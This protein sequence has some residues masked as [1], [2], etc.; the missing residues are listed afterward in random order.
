MY[1]TQLASDT[2]QKCRKKL[3][4]PKLCRFIVEFRLSGR[5]FHRYSP[6]RFS[7]RNCLYRI[8]AL[9]PRKCL[10]DKRWSYRPPLP[11]Y[12][13]I[14]KL[15]YV[16]YP[17]QI[18]TLKI[19]DISRYDTRSVIHLQ[20]NI[21]VKEFGLTIFQAYFGNLMQLHVHDTSG[22]SKNKIPNCKS[23]EHLE[24]QPSLLRLLL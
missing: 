2:V 9:S 10:N 16:K 12:Y 8:S 1:Q 6:Y 20:R 7:G 13:L 17:I 4:R 15:Q 11:V 18:G 19:N 22:S 24:S 23:S 14:L 21:T 3:T 5:V